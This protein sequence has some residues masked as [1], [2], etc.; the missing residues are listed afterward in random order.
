[1]PNQPRQD[2]HEAVESPARAARETAPPPIEETEDD[3][4]I[5]FGSWDCALVP[6]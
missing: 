6:R 1:M 2:G 5:V 3:T 4:R